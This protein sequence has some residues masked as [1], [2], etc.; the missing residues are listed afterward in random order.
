MFNFFLKNTELNEFLNKLEK[1]INNTLNLSKIYSLRADSITELI[2]SHGP[3]FIKYFEDI[4][5]GYQ[6]LSNIY[7]E[8]SQKHIRSFEDLKDISIRYPILKR[9]EKE[10]EDL[11][12]KLIDIQNQFEKS[13][14]LN[15]NIFEL[16]NKLIK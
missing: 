4:I 7:Y 12:K 11:N 15:L 2:N 6:Q 3:Y 8:T 13:K 16:K 10:K 1:D 9:L 5:K 14:K